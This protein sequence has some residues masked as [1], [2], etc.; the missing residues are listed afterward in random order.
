MNTHLMLTF[1][2]LVLV[3]ASGMFFASSADATP[4]PTVN[5]MK[6]EPLEFVSPGGVEFHDGFWGDR[7]RLIHEITIPHA[8]EQSELTGRISNF[9]KA[10]GLADGEHQGFFFNDSDVYKIVEGA[11]YSL[12]LTP[13]PELES[14]LDDLIAKIAAAQEDDGYLNTYYTLAEPENK[15]TDIRVRHELYCAGHLFE[16][17]AAHHEATGKRN[18]LD[19]ALKLADHIDSKFGPDA[20]R[21]PP[22]HEEI[23]VGLVRLYE[24]SGDKRY[25]D[26]AK[27]FIDERGNAEGHDLYGEYSQ[28][29][30][31]VTEQEEAVGHAV[32]ACYLYMGITD[33]FEH[34]RHEPY[35]DA[36]DRIWDNVVSKKLYIT[37]SVGASRAG[38]AFSENYELQN[39]S[40]YAETCAS[41]AYGMW[42]ARM[43]RL[44]HDAK[45]IDLLERVIY[46]GF[47][48]GCLWTVMSSS[49]RIRWPATG[50]RRS[51]TVRQNDP[52]GSVVRAARR[53]S[54]ASSRRWRSTRTRTT[55]IPMCSLTSTL[56]A[57][58]RL[59]LKRER[60][61]SVSTRTI[62]GM[63]TSN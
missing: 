6:V 52:N 40:A 23:E 14:Y 29:H 16:A 1:L 32:R 4:P 49:I 36:V 46:N 45:Y 56:R 50:I 43:F 3:T 12:M 55:V 31:P 25:L 62:R 42:N 2:A 30:R 19:I 41:I 10:G 35:L 28:D 5:P 38:E 54:S 44:H 47:L 33:V 53:T 11:A 26:L 18:L 60:F 63:G 8:F 61:A 37:G 59:I 20:N 9:E 24:T 51:I 58:P 15:W 27:F 48:S 22:G 21:H 17:A 57:A 39:K 7:A 13:D 34:T